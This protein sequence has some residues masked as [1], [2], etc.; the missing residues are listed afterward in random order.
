MHAF[1]AIF[2]LERYKNVIIRERE[3]LFFALIEHCINAQF[4][5]IQICFFFT[6]D[7]VLTSLD[8]NC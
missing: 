8:A 6:R 3:N 7:S 1:D 2:I 5:S 4:L